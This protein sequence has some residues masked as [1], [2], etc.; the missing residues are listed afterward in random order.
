MHQTQGIHHLGLTVRDIQEVSTFFCDQLGF[1]V[2]GKKPDYPAI[3]VSD[4]TVMLT[5]WQVP[6]GVDPVS[7]DRRRNIGLHHFALKVAD[8]CTLDKLFGR[9]KEHDGV[10]LEFGP[11]PLGQTGSRHMM[12]AIPGGI[13]I[14]FIAAA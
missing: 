9:L 6:N 1:E 4:G 13:R 10:A 7:F 12:C 5:L 3:F 14:E 11:E 8:H 2:V